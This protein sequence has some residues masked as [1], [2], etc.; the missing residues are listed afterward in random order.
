MLISYAIIFGQRTFFSIIKLVFR[1][2]HE[3][4]LFSYNGISKIAYYLSRLSRALKLASLWAKN[5]FF[6]DFV[7]KY[8]S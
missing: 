3:F 4:Y 7:Q 6:L 5:I 8:V 1:G 2:K